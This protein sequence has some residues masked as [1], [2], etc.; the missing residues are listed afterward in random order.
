DPGVLRDDMKKLMDRHDVLV[1]TGGVSA[2]A[3]DY[4]PSVLQQLGVR[5]LFHKIRQRPGKPFWVGISETDRPVVIFGLPGNPVSALIGTIRYI[6]SYLRS[7]AGDPGVDR[8]ER[9]RLAEPFT[10]DR[11][12]VLFLPVRFWCDTDGTLLA[13]PAP[14]NGSGDYA[15]LADADGFLELPAEISTF[16]AGYA[17]RLHRFGGSR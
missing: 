13:E 4:V 6:V 12:L 16:D 8:V 14:T 3:F 15:A 1:F 2:G 11:D 17:A 9:A 7:C 5:P 10:F